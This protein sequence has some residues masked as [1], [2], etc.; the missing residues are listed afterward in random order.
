MAAHEN[1]P[2][3]ELLKS[4]LRRELADQGVTPISYV[5]KTF[6]TTNAFTKPVKG[7]DELCQFGSLAELKMSAKNQLS[8]QSSVK[9]RTSKTTHMYEFLAGL[10]PEVEFLTIEEL[11][12]K[13]RIYQI[14]EL[15]LLSDT[16]RD[17][18]KEFFK[19]KILSLEK[20]NQKSTKAGLANI[21]DCNLSAII[22]EG[23]FSIIY[24]ATATINALPKV[25]AVK[26]FKEEMAVEDRQKEISFFE[27]MN[28]PY[29][30]HCFG[31][32]N[33]VNLVFE[34]MDE[35]DLLEYISDN[36]DNIPI[37]DERLAFIKKIASG[38][39]YLHGLMIVHQD[40][41][42][43]NIFVR[44]QGGEICLKIGDFGLSSYEGQF[45]DICGT[46]AYMPP[47]MTECYLSGQ[48]HLVSRSSDIYSFSMVMLLIIYWQNELLFPDYLYLPSTKNMDICI[49]TFNG[50]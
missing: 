24:K 43:E 21:D 16:S 15:Y 19:Q 12:I 35:K 46:A 42:L 28:S 10:A 36:Y 4:V 48:Q 50:G 1:D 41:K 34:L 40:L 5:I 14:D 39:L 44:I 2:A 30:L 23:S 27:K 45:N 22:A 31:L 49:Y 37:L 17:E 25:V 47:E 3:I 7:L 26:I 8:R 6:F 33:K 32:Y 11:L 18:I 38:I 13:L 29:I 9:T 20:S